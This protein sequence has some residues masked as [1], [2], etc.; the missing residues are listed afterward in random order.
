MVSKIISFDYLNAKKKDYQEFAQEFYKIMANKYHLE[1]EINF[2]SNIEE[3]IGNTLS[4]CS[5][6]INFK[7]IYFHYLTFNI[8]QL[9]K[10]NPNY[11][12]RFLEFVN[13]LYH[14]LYHVLIIELANKES[15]FNLTSLFSAIDYVDNDDIMFWD[16]NYNRLDEEIKAYIYGFKASL[17]FTK[18]Y[19]PD[20]Y[21]KEFNKKELAKFITSKYFYNHYFYEGERLSKTATLNK[22]L[23]N[24]CYEEDVSYPIII[25]KV[26]NFENKKI[27]SID[28]LVCDYEYYLS[29]YP[30]KLKE[31]KTFYATIVTEKYLD[32]ESFTMNNNVLYLI[33]LGLNLKKKTLRNLKQVHPIKLYPN[34][35]KNY[36]IQEQQNVIKNIESS[37]KGLF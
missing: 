23:N 28:E 24:F 6:D 20:A 35:I 7:T 19:Y 11:Q 1:L 12:K 34:Y 5:Y 31:I 2:S 4:I 25:N 13:C 29:K 17:S 36:Y 26:Y 9:F 27:K 33:Q 15:C 32:K 3:Y 21:D 30:Y 10:E 18:K 8:K 22:M 14:E 16:T 37:F